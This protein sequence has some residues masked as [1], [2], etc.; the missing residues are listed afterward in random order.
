MRE[1]LLLSCLL[2]APADGWKQHEAPFAAR[3]PADHGSH[4][5]FRSEWWYATGELAT[6]AGERFGYQL[7]IFRAGLEPGLPERGEPYWSARTLFAGHLALTEIGA[8]KT[9]GAE[10]LGRANGALAGARDGELDA[11]VGDWRIARDPATGVLHASGCAREIGVAL[12]LDLRPLKPPVLHGAEGLSR[13]GTEP[14][15]ASAYVSFTRLETQG[16][17]TLEG[18]TLDVCGESW[19]DHEWGSSQLGAS[20]VGWDWFGLRLSDGRE[21]MI[22]RMRRADGS[23]L[24]LPA[25]TLV[26]ADGSSRALAS[27]EVELTVEQRWTSP[28]TKAEYPARWKLSVPSEKLELR[29]VPRVPDCEIDGARSTGVLYWEGPVAVEGSL[30]GS[31]YAELTGYAGSLAG[32]F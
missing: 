25:G 22:Y 2:L 9:R 1:V 19:F 3:F 4:A 16:Q 31:G 12:E 24:E 13:K 15:N 27:S 8:Q 26:E 10:R 29:L 14:G 23:W 28:R 20:V 11:W 32:R 30:Q 21:L 5:D 7:T 6:P 17:L 18:R